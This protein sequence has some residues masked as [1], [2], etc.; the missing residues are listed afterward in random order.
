M[1]M[2]WMPFSLFLQLLIPGMN[3]QL[4]GDRWITLDPPLNME[5]AMFYFEQ[6]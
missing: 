5:E 2:A 6:E 4:P 3:N 1:W